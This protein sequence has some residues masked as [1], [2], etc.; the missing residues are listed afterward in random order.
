M[1]NLLSFACSH[2]RSLTHTH[3]I[4]KKLKLLEFFTMICEDGF[5]IYEAYL[6]DEELVDNDPSTQE[7]EGLEDR[8]KN[9]KE[10]ILKN[11]IA[12]DPKTVI[13]D[14]VAMIDDLHGFALTRWLPTKDEVNWVEFSLDEKK[15]HLHMK[16]HGFKK[17]VRRMTLMGTAAPTL[18]TLASESAKVSAS[19]EPSS[20]A[21]RRSSKLKR[22]TSKGHIALD[23]DSDESDDDE[24]PLT[25]FASQQDP[26]LIDISM[27]GERTPHV[28]RSRAI[29]L[30]DRRL[31]HVY[32]PNEVAGYGSEADDVGPAVTQQSEL[33]THS[34]TGDNQL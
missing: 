8:L 10:H 23:Q 31:L 11:L 5:V 7:C 24:V 25:V 28:I 3:I 12:H 20:S 19:I 13:E 16:D 34:S 15:A 32:D 1:A 17:K 21:K 6:K 14:N 29:S 30:M 18:H 2:T 4:V 22:V 26:E 27:A 33:L 9:L